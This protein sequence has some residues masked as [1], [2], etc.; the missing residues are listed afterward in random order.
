MLDKKKTS[1]RATTSDIKYKLMMQT[2]LRSPL[3]KRSP[4]A[5]HISSRLAF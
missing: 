2:D 4:T 5:E 3:T 1:M